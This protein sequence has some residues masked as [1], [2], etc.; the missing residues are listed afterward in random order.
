MICRSKLINLELESKKTEN[1]KLKNLSAR[2]T[3][4]QTSYIREGIILRVPKN[5]CPIQSPRKPNSHGISDWKIE[6][7]KRLLDSPTH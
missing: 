6:I 3:V 1:V 5:M 7:L 4:L 2:E